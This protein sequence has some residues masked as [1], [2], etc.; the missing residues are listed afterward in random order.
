MA[1]AIKYVWNSLAVVTVLRCHACQCTV[2]AAL[3]GVCGCGVLHTLLV[4]HHAGH[5]V[6]QWQPG[7]GLSVCY[8]TVIFI[9]MENS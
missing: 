7:P 5:V 2:C 3:T 8:S 9:C 4:A 6:G 1:N